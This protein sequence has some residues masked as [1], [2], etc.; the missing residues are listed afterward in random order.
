MFDFSQYYLSED[1]FKRVLNYR[2]PLTDHVNLH[3][4]FVLKQSLSEINGVG[5]KTLFK[6]CR[7][8][9]DYIDEYREWKPLIPIS[10]LEFCF[11]ELNFSPLVREYLLQHFIYGAKPSAIANSYGVSRQLVSRYCLLVKDFFSDFEP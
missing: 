11:S 10:D 5:Y 4:V 6:R 1:E 2:N 9:C 7:R 3:K 8:F